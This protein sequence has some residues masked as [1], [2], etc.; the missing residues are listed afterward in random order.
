MKKKLL[1]AAG[2]I[3]IT[4][5]LL[6]LWNPPAENISWEQRTMGTRCHITIAEK[7]SKREL[8]ELR[9]KIDAALNDVEQ[10]MS[11]W[12]TDS[13]ISTFNAFDSTEL[14]AVS[15]AFYNVVERA[16][17]ISKS[18]GGAFDPTVKPLVDFFGF[19]AEKNET[20]VEEILNA[21]GWKKIQL[22]P[23]AAIRKLHPGVQLDLSAI[24][25]GY[26][27]DRVAEEIHA[28]SVKN[29]IVEIGGEIRAEGK[30]SKGTNWRVGIETPEADKPFGAVILQSI[31]LSGRALATSGS[32]RQ[33]KT[34]AA[35]V[36]VSHLVDPRTGAPAE[37]DIA[38]VTVL[39]D[40]CIDAD[41]AAT[42]LFVLGS[43]AALAWLETRPELSAHFILH[44]GGEIFI[45]QSSVN[46]PRE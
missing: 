37:T 26:G 40:R 22:C 39:A 18:T 6:R 34:N 2:G 7:I 1:I 33:F 4:A 25:K 9:E 14:F 21:V 30:N 43:D 10:Q 17:E 23:P 3:L 44:A 46:W 36:R 20:P 35:G 31:E 8:S 19:G 38:S 42:A 41:A 16:L 29:F 27:V 15:P 45:I 11:V 28:A 24:A 5:A 13:E 12:R 32:Y